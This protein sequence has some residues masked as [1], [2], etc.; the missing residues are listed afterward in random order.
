MML[1][2]GDCDGDVRWLNGGRREC[3]YCV[4]C[5]LLVMF[6][7]ERLRWLDTLI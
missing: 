5:S 3:L 1:G 6:E 4:Y 7:I 2:V